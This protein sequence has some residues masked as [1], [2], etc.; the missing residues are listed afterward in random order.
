MSMLEVFLLALSLALLQRIFDFLITVLMLALKKL[1]HWNCQTQQD[2]HESVEIGPSVARDEVEGFQE[3]PPSV[4]TGGK[5]YVVKR[6]Y[7]PGIYYRWS[8]CEREVS[9]F[10]NAKYR[11]FRSLEEAELYLRQ[12]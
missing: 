3:F 6:G 12:V 8:D 1:W 5:I 11:G 9:G 2:R 4:P 10:R 7:T